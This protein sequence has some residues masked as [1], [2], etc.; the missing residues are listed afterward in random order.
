MSL[1]TMAERARR[2]LA[3]TDNLFTII[4]IYRR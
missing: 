1:M 3:M 2:L 4:G